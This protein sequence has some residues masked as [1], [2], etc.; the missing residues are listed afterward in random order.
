MVALAG[1]AT[2]EHALHDYPSSGKPRRCAAEN[3]DRGRGGL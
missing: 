1:P 3:A 2:A